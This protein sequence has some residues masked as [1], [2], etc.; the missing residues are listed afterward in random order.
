M[1]VALKH[2]AP[3]AD[4]HPMANRRAAP[5][6]VIYALAPL[7]SM[8]G[9]GLTLS[10][11]AGL[12]DMLL[13]PVT[14]TI[15]GPEPGPGAVDPAPIDPEPIERDAV[16][17]APASEP[18]PATEAPPAP[19]AP[20]PCAG[21]LDSVA[22]AGLPLPDGVGFRCPSTEYAHQGAACWVTVCPSAYIAINMDRL[23]D[24]SP[25]YLRHV[26][27]HEI[28]HILDWQTTGRTS[29]AGADACAAGYGF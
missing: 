13:E 26:V 4:Q 7:L 5:R 22:Q 10:T 20:E 17:P 2:R 16:E 11:R 23:V 21:A 19:P 25:E 14:A 24:A 27:A 9:V 6:W 1:A 28:C 29:E 8:M 12:A 15:A 3:D 18:T